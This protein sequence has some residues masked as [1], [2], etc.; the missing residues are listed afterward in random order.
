MSQDYTLQSFN[1][2]FY[3]GRLHFDDA[4]VAALLSPDRRATGRV[5][6]IWVNHY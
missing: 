2:A 5:P 4:V 1:F 6:A 3:P